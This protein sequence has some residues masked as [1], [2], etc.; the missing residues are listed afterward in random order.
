M[1]EKDRK[2]SP[3]LITIILL[4]GLFLIGFTIWYVL[5]YS[6]IKEPVITPEE[7]SKIEQIEKENKITTEQAQAYSSLITIDGSYGFYID[8]SVSIDDISDFNMISYILNNY[9]KENK[10]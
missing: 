5:N 8:K 2:F 4:L 1:E 7:Q 3:V 10:V 6:N 9:V